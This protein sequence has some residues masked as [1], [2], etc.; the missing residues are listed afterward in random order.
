LGG[1][2]IKIKTT[3]SLLNVMKELK[4]ELDAR[5]QVVKLKHIITVRRF[6]ISLALVV[7]KSI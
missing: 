3:S 1:G 4:Y 7:W 5:K 6:F 2:Q